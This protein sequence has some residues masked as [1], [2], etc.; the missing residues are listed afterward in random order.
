MDLAISFWNMPV[1]IIY[2]TAAMLFI[3]TAPLP[4]GYYNL[5][6]LVATIVFIWAAFV[7]YEKKNDTL[8][9]VYGGLALLFNPIMKIH[10]PKELWVII[11]IYAGVLHW[12]PSLVETH[13]MNMEPQ[14]RSITKRI[15]EGDLVA[16]VKCERQKIRKAST[17]RLPKQKLDTTRRPLRAGILSEKY[18]KVLHWTRPLMWIMHNS[19]ISHHRH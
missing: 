1:A 3:G 2:I 18:E 11:D 15:R 19:V 5:L 10:L 16:N 7:A 13:E 14:V 4:Y 8:P 6:R 17:C 9:W 12:L